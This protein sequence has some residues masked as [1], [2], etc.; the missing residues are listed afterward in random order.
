MKYISWTIQSSHHYHYRGICIITDL[1]RVEKDTP[2]ALGLKQF[3]PAQKRKEH[4]LKG[5]HASLGNHKEVYL[6]L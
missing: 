6:V 1:Q 2:Y 5:V 3:V 4:V